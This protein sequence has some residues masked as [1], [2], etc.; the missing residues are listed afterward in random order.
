MFGQIYIIQYNVNRKL[1]MPGGSHLM[2][3]TIIVT[4]AASGI[5]L[6]VAQWF[7]R[8]GH[9]VSMMDMNGDGVRSASAALNAEGGS[10]LAFQ[11]DVAARD[12]VAAAIE[13]TRASLGPIEI[14]IANAGISEYVP[15][16]EMT[17]ASWQ[18][19]LDINLTG[20]FHCIQLAIP[21]MLAAQWGRIVTISSMSAQVGAPSMAHYAA[22]KGG[23]TSLTKAIAREFADKGI[24][25][26]TIPP[27]LIHT[28]LSRRTEVDG[29]NPRIDAMVQMHPVKR[30]GMPEDIAAACDWLCSEH[31]GFVTGQEINLNGG[32]Y[33]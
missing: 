7:A 9:R 27:S 25:A 10:T 26:N 30:I 24:T 4:G 3:R 23:V 18:R 15:F 31:S 32:M 29:K 22:S 2:A 17:V 19:M 5:G 16:T 6:G 13:E 12:Q 21:D 14:L 20:M 1:N 11:V 8:K 33:S 28:G